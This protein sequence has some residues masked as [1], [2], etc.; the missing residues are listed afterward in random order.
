MTAVLLRW[1]VYALVIAG[2][3]AA[4][5]LEAGLDSADRFF[6]TGLTE[7]VQ[8]G[9]AVLIVMLML[10]HAW[11]YP[12]LRPVTIQLAGLFLMLAIREL[13]WWTDE[14]IGDHTWQIG[15]SL[16]LL[17]QIVYFWQIRHCWAAVWRRFSNSAAFGAVASGLLVLTVFSRLFGRETVWE[18]VMGS[19]Y[20]RIVKNAAEESIELLGFAL[21]LIGSIELWF[22]FRR[23]TG[24]ESDKDPNL[25]R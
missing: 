16:V 3:A 6:E 25:S 13:D 7:R 5:S 19:G 11:R 21:V 20:Q 18:A 12:P 24:L 23:K 2:F 4:V 1:F 8:L 22:Q 15:V 17:W 10:V 9:C 14:V